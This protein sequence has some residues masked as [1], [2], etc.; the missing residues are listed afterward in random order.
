MAEIVYM[1]KL[2][3]TMTE[4]VVAEWTK[5][6]GDSVESGEIL[7][8]IETDKATMEFESFFDGVLLHI[9]I[10]KG[11]AAP[12]NSILAIIGEKGDDVKK[13]LAEAEKNSPFAKEPKKE[14]T[15]VTPEPV[16]EAPKT[17]V[18]KETPKPVQAASVADSNGRLFASPLAKKMAN[19]QGIDL[20]TIKGTGDSGRIVKR[21]IDHYTPYVGGGAKRGF[22]GV[23][24]FT[25]EP[26]SQMRKVIAKRLAESKFS[27]PHFYLTLD[28]DM[29]NAIS[30]RKSMNAIEGIKVSYNDMVI[31]ACALALREH[32][33]VNSSWL[34]DV[35]RTNDHVHIGVAV[36]V[37]EGLLVPVV[38]FADGKELTSIG[39]EVKELAIKAKTKKLQPAEWEGN[40]FTIS[41]L[42]MFGIE[43]FTAIVNP[44]DSCIMAVGGIKQVPVVK[45]GNV[46]PG[47]VM[48]I[49]LSCDHRVVDGASGAAFLNTFKNLMENPVSLILK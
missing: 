40:T 22:V 3:D 49:T 13:I 24:S 17:V 47:N 35:I 43:E 12:V 29:D 32:P 11:V 20:S 41:N 25:D 23:E 30:T 33:R 26:I 46:V 7:A 34:G 18:A 2:S 21:D 38:R 28:I 48:K 10:E 31:K 8:E 36:A 9:G 39:A 14:E 4:G 45:D 15:S 27:A 19:D 6:V 16:K 44:P 5:K 1:P 42:G 37:D